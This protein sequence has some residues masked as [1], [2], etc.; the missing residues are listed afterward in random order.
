MTT[1]GFNSGESFNAN[2]S[3]DPNDLAKPL[4]G[5]ALGASS[6]NDIRT[7]NQRS[8]T[9]DANLLPG[10]T[11]LQITGV[12]SAYDTRRFHQAQENRLTRRLCLKREERLSRTPLRNCPA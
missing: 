5:I 9:T 11:R 8:D 2:E 3:P 12:D 6:L 10:I 1:Q 4:A 7:I